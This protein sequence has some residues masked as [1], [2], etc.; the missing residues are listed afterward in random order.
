MSV[1]P[2]KGMPPPG[3]ARNHYHPPPHATNI[4]PPSAR[5][6]ASPG[7]PTSPLSAPSMKSPTLS[8]AGPVVVVASPT[9]L[10][11]R[12]PQT[13]Q[14]RHTATYKTPPAGGRSSS[15]SPTRLLAATSS[16]PSPAAVP[17]AAYGSG[18]RM[19]ERSSSVASTAA[20]N[21]TDTQHSILALERRKAEA[22][23]RE[24]FPEAQ[25]LKQR[26]EREKAREEREQQ[27]RDRAAAAAAASPAAAAAAP[28]SS[29]LRPT[30]SAPAA[31]VDD[32]SMLSSAVSAR[33]YAAAGGV[34]VSACEVKLTTLKGEA[35]LHVRDLRTNEWESASVGDLRRI[36]IGRHASGTFEAAEG[37]VRGLEDPGLCVSLGFPHAQ[38]DL[39]FAEPEWFLRLVNAASAMSRHTAELHP[40]E[41]TERQR[42]ARR[43]R[44]RPG[45]HRHREAAA[46]VAVAADGGGRARHLPAFD[47]YDSPH[48]ERDAARGG[49]EVLPQAWPGQQQQQ[50]GPPP[51][52]VSPVRRNTW[53]EMPT[54]PP[55]NNSPVY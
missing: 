47:A 52:C 26:L 16:A 55:R 23:A 50:P 35:T 30:A 3:T 31:P 25:R 28:A 27:E 20:S 14:P 38:Y 44:H 42:Q 34:S 51:R 33:R 37:S 4:A 9:A 15:P 19:D 2:T 45:S 53:Q 46:A 7:P 24:D 40:R 49:N 41:V 43:S 54:A 22:V 1:Y 11:T 10:R 36:D 13:H 8:P 29:P 12:P 17:A 5:R 18:A 32:F 39:E 6:A 48:R 21:L